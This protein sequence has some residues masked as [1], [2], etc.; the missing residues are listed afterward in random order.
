[1]MKPIPRTKGPALS[2]AARRRRG[3]ITRVA[4]AGF[5]RGTPIGRRAGLIGIGFLL[6]GFNTGNNLFYLVFTVLAASELVGFLV[7]RAAL[8]RLDVEVAL[9]RRAQVGAPVRP[10]ITLIN[11]GG[12]LPVP[13]LCWTLRSQGGEEALVRT[14]AIAPGASASG[15]G[16]LTPS[17]RGSLEIASIE[18]HSEFPLGLTRTAVRIVD[19]SVRTLVAPRLAGSRAGS[20]GVRR[21]DVRRLMHPKGAGEEPIDAREYVPGDDARRIDWRASARA[22]RLVWRDRRGDPPRAIQVR[23]ERGGVEGVEFEARVSRAGGAAAEALA[24]GDAVGFS[25]DEWD[26]LPRSG[27]A[28]R[29]RILDYLALVRPRGD[30]GRAVELRS[31]AARVG[32]AP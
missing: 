3:E 14:P 13:A 7:A 4:V 32:S 16:S 28:Q 18:A 9:P 20:V 21:G 25:T 10:T 23:L 15:T 12:W 24:R 29:R 11:R 8:S 27:P 22:E 30:G 6:A 1:M 31:A 19:S 2:A 5:P 26:L 17:R